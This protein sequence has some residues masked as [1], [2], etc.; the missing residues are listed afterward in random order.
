MTRPTDSWQLGIDFGTSYTV[1]AVAS[2]SGV[3]VLDIESNGQSRMPSSVFYT[4]SGEILVGSAAQ[5]QAAFAP[6]RFEATPKRSIADGEIFLGDDFIGV[7]TLIAGVLRK[8]FTEASRQRGETL[9]QAVRL[10]HPAEWGAARLELLREAAAKAGLPAVELVPEPVAAAVWIAGAVT[11]PGERIAVYDFGGGTF[12]AAV[13]RRTVD[14]FEVAGPPAGRDPLGGEDIDRR[15][16]DFI[17][18]VVASD[19]SDDWASLT[20]PKDVTWRRRAIALR[21]EVQ[22]A[23]ETL[24]EVTS[25]QLWIPGLE[26]ELQLTRAE[27][28][29][30]ISDDLD[31]CTQTL[32]TALHDASV[33]ADEL[34][35]LY[36]VGGSSRIPVVAEKLWRRFGIAPSVQDSPKSVVALGA[37]RWTDIGTQ[38][39]A[40]AQP[41]ERTVVTVAD[42]TPA[43]ALVWTDQG[44]N[45]FVPPS[46]ALTLPPQ[47][48]GWRAG[49]TTFQTVDRV[50]GPPAT[51]R[52]R[53]EPNRGGDAHALAVRAGAVRAARSPTFVDHGLRPWAAAGLPGLERSFTIS[54]RGVPIA[55]LERYAAVGDRA[56]VMAFPAQHVVL[57]DA[58][59]P[60]GWPS[61]PGRAAAPCVLPQPPGW[62]TSEEIRLV[63]PDGHRV[64]QAERLE[65]PDEPEEAWRWHRLEELLR[66]LPE[67]GMA[68]R[69]AGRVMGL[70]GEVVTVRW[71]TPAAV[72]LTKLGTATSSG[73]GFVLTL[74]LPLAAQ[75]DFP[76]FAGM[77][78]VNAAPQV[79]AAS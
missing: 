25:C 34:Q 32:L 6:E 40:T 31:E 3:A 58:V 59:A 57:A 24:S 50:H 38:V 64:V 5:H 10:T 66:D 18:S 39:T 46:L 71:R 45:A 2:S 7:T 15:V 76:M 8:V 30:L 53:D 20:N 35:G 33:T 22:R 56:L 47:L 11:H 77:L 12:D 13:L 36:L 48:A 21:M 37:A 61:P 23:K 67:A 68:G 17:G 72:M 14:G 26:R 41:S 28:E 62:T 51:I 4:E 73:Q 44:G 74:T 54:P 69:A 19:S 1:A 75:A 29:N 27:L 42:E 60:T 78:S 65:L 9:P 49:A 16:I 79:P 43:L 63:G 70:P 52:L 55:M